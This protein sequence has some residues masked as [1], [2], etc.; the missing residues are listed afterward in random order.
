MTP[1][2]YVWLAAATTVVLTCAGAC[3]AGGAEPDD[4][5]PATS[6]PSGVASPPSATTPPA[7]PTS[8]C[9]D[10]TL[11]ELDL[12]GRVGQ[13]LML[14][15]DAGGS[16]DQAIR[17]VTEHHLGSVTLIGRSYAGD[18]AVR[19][20]TD[21]LQAAADLPLFVGTDQEGGHVQV[22][23]GPGF[24]EMPSAEEQGQLPV[25]R[26]ERR[27]ERWGD[28]LASAGVNL[29]LAPVLDVVP[30]ALGALNQPIGRYDRA[31]GST[32]GGVTSHGLAF[33]RGMSAAG[34]VPVVKHFPGLGAVRGNPDVRV[35]VVDA[36]T[37]PTSGAAAPFRAAVAAGVPMVMVSSAR[38]ARLDPNEL[39]LF[40]EAI[41]TGLLREELGFTGVVITDDV[42]A[43]AAVRA[44]APVAERAI[45]FLEAGGDLI[46]TVQ[47]ADV[48][49]MAAAL[50]ER[51]ERRPAFA[52]L[53][54]ASVQR[55]L[56]AKDAAGLLT[57]ARA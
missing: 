2:R 34:V 49:T 26:L 1:L 23:H 14:G 54:D 19:A 18:G 42:G 4:V 45:R 35:N 44:E 28:A 16:P 13:L 51:A 41:I 39:A 43:A 32:P 15:F 27:S 21:R 52:A 30:A 50:A 8:S 12:P 7:S 25:S 5:I 9:V 24:P 40:S 33:A 10:Q 11:A 46:L 22:L 55:V 17:L 29:N 38:Y 37:T 36:T 53:V 57:C 47:A 20:L 6:P 48:P 3:D 56:T 31:Y